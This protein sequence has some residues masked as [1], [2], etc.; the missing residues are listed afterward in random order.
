MLCRTAH[1]YHAVKMPL[2]A[3]NGL[4]EDE[5]LKQTGGTSSLPS[6]KDSF[7]M[8]GY[9]FMQNIQKEEQLIPHVI[10]H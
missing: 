10:S 3:Q 6:V 7:I 9:P 5:N 4:H 2:P 1:I 8:T